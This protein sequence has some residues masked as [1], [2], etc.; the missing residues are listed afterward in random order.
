MQYKRRTAREMVM[1][2]LYALELSNDSLEHIIETILK[3]A[4]KKDPDLLEF[5]EKL[6]LLTVRDIKQ[7][8]SIISEFA[9]NW[10]IKRIAVLDKS[11]LRMALVE[12]MH[13]NDIPTN[14]TINEVI[15]IAKNYS[16]PKS[17]KFINGILDAASAKL[18]E[19]GLIKKSISEI[20]KKSL[21]KQTHS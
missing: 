8:D 19:Q 7:L 3:P 20:P 4:F 21:K 17:G 1:K 2:A 14:V 16:T 6:F 10:D 15:E 11:L 13:F 9:D 5:S 12:M 18:E